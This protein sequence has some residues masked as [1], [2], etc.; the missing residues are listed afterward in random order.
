MSRDWTKTV[1][2][3]IEPILD[4]HDIILSFRLLEPLRRPCATCGH[5]ADYTGNYGDKVYEVD[6][7]LFDRWSHLQREL[8]QVNDQLA[9]ITRNTISNRMYNTRRNANA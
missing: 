2:V 4:K 5:E 7:Q 3:G 6:Q 9:Y 8:K 1:R